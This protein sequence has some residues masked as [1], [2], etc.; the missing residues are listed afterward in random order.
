MGGHTQHIAERPV[1]APASILI[2]DDRPTSRA[3]VKGVLGSS[4]YVTTEATSG[5]QAIDLIR[6]QRFDLVILDILMPDMD[7]LSVL[8]TIRESHSESRLPVIMATVKH[9]TG[10]MVAALEHGANDYVTKPIDF[11]VLLARIRSQLARKRGEDALRRASSGLALEVQERTAALDRANDVLQRVEYECRHAERAKRTFEQQLRDFAQVSADWFWEMDAE[12]RFTYVS[13]RF[14]SVTGWAPEAILGRTRQEIYS[15]RGAEQEMWSQHFRDLE[16][17]RPFQNLDFIWVRPDQSTRALSLSG[18]PVYDEKGVFKGYRGAGRDATE[19]HNLSEELSYRS[20]H[21]TLTGLVNRHEFEHRL[22]RALE[23]TRLRRVLSASGARTT[24]HVLCY[25][26]LDQFKI[27][28]DTCGHVAGDELLR[29]IGALLTDKIRR[30]DTVAR[31]GGD[32]FGVLMEDCSLE[33]AQRVANSVREAVERFVFQWEDKRFNVGVS[34]GIA[35]INQL[36]PSIIAALS[37]AD[38]ACYAAKEQGRNRIHVYREDDVDLARRH[39]EMQWVERISRALEKNHF[40]LYYQPIVPIDGRLEGAHY[41][42]LLRLEDEQGE[43]VPPGVFLPAAE[44]YNLSIRVDRWVVRESFAW[45]E[46]HPERMD[47]LHQCSI[48][49]SGHSLGDEQF[50]AFITAQLEARKIPACKICFEV[51]ETAA[52]A[53][54]VRATRFIKALKSLGCLFSLDDFGSGLSS[55]AYLKNL[56]VDILKI[57]GVFVKDIVDDPI[58]LAMVRSINE[59]GHVMRK[60]T[61]AEFVEDEAILEKLRETGV[62]YAQGFMVG[63]P[64]PVDD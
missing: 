42:F 50:L 62:D 18:K 63:R 44:R 4:N 28:N 10:D 58:D 2:V 11:P 20:R 21:D 57:D 51:T 48:N 6:R 1:D 7:G 55:F 47:A 8:K 26:D 34:I 16:M 31:L 13:D 53:N 49:L 25:L 35:P 56:P 3:V 15:E 24:E 61:V 29:Q 5:I 33:Q 19:A 22:R 54:L 45:L 40:R 17:R 32:E 60:T 64:R 12:L 14:E 41:E 30:R 52:I 37:A 59:I 38:S 46:R 27:I 43:I 9:D 36:T 23:T 39:G